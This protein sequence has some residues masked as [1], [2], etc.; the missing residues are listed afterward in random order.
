VF[1]IAQEILSRSLILISQEDTKEMEEIFRS[2]GFVGLLVALKSPKI[3]VLTRL[4]NTAEL[5]KNF[6]N[7][8]RE[9]VERI[10]KEAQ[11]VRNLNGDKDGKAESRKSASVSKKARQAFNGD[12]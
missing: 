8:E 5:L 4:T 1:H 10:E 2:I 7:R 3:K 12:S 6:S 11:S 9:E